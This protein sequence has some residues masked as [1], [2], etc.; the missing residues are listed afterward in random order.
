MRLP[1]DPEFG[2]LITRKKLS[3]GSVLAMVLVA[4]IAGVFSLVMIPMALAPSG[5]RGSSPKSFVD[6]LPF[7]VAPGAGIGLVLLLIYRSAQGIRFHESGVVTTLFGKTIARF[8]YAD[9]V[10]HEFYMVHLKHYGNYQGSMVRLSLKT[11]DKKS[12]R[13]N[14]KHVLE[15]VRTGGFFTP[16]FKVVGQ[17]TIESVAWRAAYTI[18]DQWIARLEA[19]ESIEWTKLATLTPAGV[20]SWHGPSKGTMALYSEL[21]SIDVDGSSAPIMMGDGTPFVSLSTRDV[22][23]YPGYLAAIALIDRVSPDSDFIDDDAT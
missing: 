14:A 1:T 19:G 5:S 4:I 12:V 3:R 18:A 13:Y 6:L 8:A 2:P 17:S 10:A 11:A 22:N 15:S 21:A 20:A 16:D 9:C 7:L 23:F